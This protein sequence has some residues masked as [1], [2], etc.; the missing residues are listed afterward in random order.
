MPFASAASRAAYFAARAGRGIVP[1]T[2]LGLK[3]LST[4]RRKL[5]L[6]RKL[7]RFAFGTDVVAS[8]GGAGAAAYFAS[9]DIKHARKSQRRREAALSRFEASL[10]GK[11]PRVRRLKEK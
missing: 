4:A 7:R 8:I 2:R 5:I 1:V 10:K 3:G 9:K 6:S 11:N